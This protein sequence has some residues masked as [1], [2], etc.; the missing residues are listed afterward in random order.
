M[1]GYPDRAPEAA[2]SFTLLVDGVEIVASEE[3]EQMEDDVDASDGERRR[4]DLE[5][6]DARRRREERNDARLTFVDEIKDED[7]GSVGP[8]QSPLGRRIPAQTPL[9]R[10]KPREGAHL[11]REAEA[12]GD[13]VRPPRRVEARQK[14]EMKW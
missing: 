10:L 8:A 1:I 14:G 4:R 12:P 5:R 7:G 13:T 9:C 3:A 6:D 2:L 11:P